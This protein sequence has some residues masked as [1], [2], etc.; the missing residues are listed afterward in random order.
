MLYKHT[1]LHSTLKGSPPL[2]AAES[3]IKDNF[4]GRNTINNK[5]SI[6]HDSH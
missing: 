4:G 1:E 2:T 5:K 3:Y 6:S